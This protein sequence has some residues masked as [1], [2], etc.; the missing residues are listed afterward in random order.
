MRTVQGSLQH[1]DFIAEAIL[2]AERSGAEKSF[3]ELVFGFSEDETLELIRK[4]LVE[5]IPGSEFHTES[6]QLIELDGEIVGGCAA[7]IENQDGLSSNSIRANLLAYTLG[8]AQLL[9]QRDAVNALNEIDIERTTGTLQIEAVYLRDGYRGKGVIRKAFEAC[10]NQHESFINEIQIQSV[11]ENHSSARAFEKAG[12]TRSE[13]KT[14]TN[15]K[16]K[17]VFLGTGKV[18]WTKQIG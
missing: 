17:E 6:Y 7:W 14:S 16:L 8:A 18:L 4:M 9:A 5:N 13:E 2:N 10:L 11:L 15:P 3:Y 1:I 12:F